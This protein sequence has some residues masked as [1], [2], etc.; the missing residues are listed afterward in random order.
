MRKIWWMRRWSVRSLG[1]TPLSGAS[2]AV[3]AASSA[4]DVEA[5][6]LTPPMMTVHS[7]LTGVFC[8]LEHLTIFHCEGC[9]D[10][11]INYNAT[12]R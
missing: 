8:Y 3:E 6:K 10:H 12:V 9:L 11:D 1:Q 4:S 2:S 7:C 5:P